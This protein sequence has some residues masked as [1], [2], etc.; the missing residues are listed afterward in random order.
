MRRLPIEV[1][2]AVW[3]GAP[4]PSKV[5]WTVEKLFDSMMEVIV[6]SDGKGE[7][8]RWNNR[9]VPVAN[10]RSGMTGR[11]KRHVAVDRLRLHS[12]GRTTMTARE[13][14]ARSQIVG[15]MIAEGIVERDNEV[16]TYS[17]GEHEFM[18]EVKVFDVTEARSESQ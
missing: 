9:K 7:T 4:D 10:L 16:L 13:I 8:Q 1:G 17:V 3:I 5:H 6:G 11:L 15:E 2:D 18:V 12:K 14:A